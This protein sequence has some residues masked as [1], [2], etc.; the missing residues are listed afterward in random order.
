M[1]FALIEARNEAEEL[2]KSPQCPRKSNGRKIGIMELTKTIWEGKGYESLGKSSQNLRDQYANIM[3]KTDLN[4]NT[5]TNEL[6]QQCANEP[7]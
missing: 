5:V 4:K 7:E 6:Q 2:H 1:N 3:K